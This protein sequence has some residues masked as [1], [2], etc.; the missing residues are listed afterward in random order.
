MIDKNG[1]EEQPASVGASSSSRLA[2]PM[3][4]D[5]MGREAAIPFIKDFVEKFT[6]EAERAAPYVPHPALQ[7]PP[8]TLLRHF[9]QCL[10]MGNL[11]PRNRPL[12]RIE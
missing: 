6:G 4:L 5:G 12:P 7:L 8:T 3:A 10:G 9:V 1:E 2:P 11:L